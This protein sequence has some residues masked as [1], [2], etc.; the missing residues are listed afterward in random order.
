MGAA[1]H[2]SGAGR[3]RLGKGFRPRGE[4]SWRFRAEQQAGEAGGGGRADCRGWQ[5]SY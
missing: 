4:G 5:S 1:A 2:R 3:A